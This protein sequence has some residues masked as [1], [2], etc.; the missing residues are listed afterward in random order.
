MKKN[1]RFVS[2]LVPGSCPALLGMP[3]IEK[4][5][6]LTINYKATGRQLSSVDNTDNRKGN[7]Q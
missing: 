7:C 1:K 5:G 4:L 2:F 3:D 6:V